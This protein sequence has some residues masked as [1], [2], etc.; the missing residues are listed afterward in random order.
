MKRNAILILLLSVSLSSAGAAQGSRKKPAKKGTNAAANKRAGGRKAAT[1]KPDAP[2]ADAAGATEP[3][4]EQSAEP[5]PARKTVAKSKKRKPA[6][7]EAVPLE[8]EEDEPKTEEQLKADLEAV[9]QMTPE[10]RVPRLRFFLQD[11]PQTPLR[12]RATEQLVSSLAALGD[13]KLQAGNEAG[14]EHFR[15]A[16]RLVPAELPDNLYVEVVS[17]FPA[18]LFLRGQTEAALEVAREIEAKVKDS[19]PRLL[20]VAAFYVSVEQ[21][22]EAVRVSEAAATLAPDLAAAH[23]ARGAAYRMELK[24]EDAAAAYAH[25]LELD[26]NSAA[27]RRSLADLY[28]A[29][30][31]A[32]EALALYRRQLEADAADGPTRAGLILSLFDA[33]RREEA[34]RELDAALKENPSQLSLLAGAAYWYAANNEPA[35]ALELAGQAVQLEPRYTWGQI[36]LARALLASRRPLEAERA[37]RYARQHG[38]FPTLDYE[39]A[40]ALAAAGLYEEAAEEL[41]RTFTLEGDQL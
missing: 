29:T 38:R 15:E 19:A 9:L 8:E 28:R 25:A 10:Q 26:P 21:G 18:N 3:G 35:R 4:G 24:L 22:E 13:M 12:V 37:L 36:A 34:E 32:E 41:A 2:A 16:L 5:A 17:R 31:K 27:V 23:L 11:Y 7:A 30:G 39:L 40:G 1:K 6:D 20:L 33:G 14:V